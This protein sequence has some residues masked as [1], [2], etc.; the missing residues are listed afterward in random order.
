MLP[1][2]NWRMEPAA[3]WTLSLHNDSGWLPQFGNASLAG[4]GLSVDYKRG[5]K[6]EFV[7]TMPVVEVGDALILR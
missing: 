2:I 3:D 1:L 4:T 6:G 5:N 7:F